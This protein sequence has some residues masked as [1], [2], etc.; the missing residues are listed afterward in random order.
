[1]AQR[2]D[3]LEELGESLF[4]FIMIDDLYAWLD[5]TEKV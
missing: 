5:R 1:M 3:R 4:D 2:L